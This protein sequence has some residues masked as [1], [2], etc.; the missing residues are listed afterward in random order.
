MHTSLI[1]L[2][3][4][5]FAAFIVWKNLDRRTPA[6]KQ[7]EFD[8][9]QTL[10]QEGQ[11]DAQYKLLMLYYD[12]KDTQF[13]PLA[14]KWALVVAQKGEDPGVMLQVGEMY[15]NGEG[16]SK[17]LQDALT[18]YERALSADTALGAQ[19]PLSKDGH[20]Y[21]EQRIFSLRQQLTPSNK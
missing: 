12:E 2:L 4:L 21:L 10:A 19:S 15:E 7:A 8:R 14:F 16:I 18:W 17:S 3:V 20:L 13:H 11:E 1:V 9:L 6:Q 5:A